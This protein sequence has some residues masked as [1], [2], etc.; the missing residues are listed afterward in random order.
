MKIIK[1]SLHALLVILMA[2]VCSYAVAQE[3]FQSAE[4]IEA[5]TGNPV[6]G[7]G[8][9][10][11]S[12]D[13]I[14]ARLSTS[15]LQKNSSYTVW[16]V[17]FNTPSNCIMP[18][19][20]GP[21]DIFLNGA[22]P[23]LNITQINLAEISVLYAAGFITGNDGVA[24]VTAHLN[25]GEPPDGLAVN[26]GWMGMSGLKTGNG[27]NAEVHMVVRSHGLSERSAWFDLAVGLATSTFMG[28]CDQYNFCF[29]DQAIIFSPL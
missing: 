4:M 19:A 20:C 1:N 6:V 3:T 10:L 11:R 2:S 14:T 29:D 25:A 24:N 12:N 22:S 7:G 9:L 21:P 26:F 17:V 28:E 27:H 15:G 23:P 16:W 18:G 5:D 8:V 13:S